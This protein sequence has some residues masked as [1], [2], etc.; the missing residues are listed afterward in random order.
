MLLTYSGYTLEFATN[1]A[2]SVSQQLLPELAL[3]PAEAQEFESL[4]RNV[5]TSVGQLQEEH[6]RLGTRVASCVGGAVISLGCLPDKLNPVIRP[7]MDCIKSETDAV[8]QVGVVL[9]QIVHTHS[10]A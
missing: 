6:Q 1:L 7:L 10:V 3:G 2:T 8:L 5:L 9:I 4:R